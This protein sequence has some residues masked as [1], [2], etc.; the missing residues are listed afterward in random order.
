M[1]PDV[2]IV[3]GGVIGLSLADCLL[4]EGLSVTILDKGALGQEASW[5]GAGMLTCRP[6]L[7][8]ASKQIAEEMCTG[9]EQPHP[10]TEECGQAEGRRPKAEGRNG[11]PP[12]PPLNEGG[13]NGGRPQAATPVS[14]EPDI[15][16][17]KLLSVRRFPVWAERLKAETG[18]DI[19]YRVCGALEV[20]APGEDAAE[21]RKRLA[22][23]AAGCTARGV[24]AEWRSGEELRQRERNLHREITGGL[25]FPDEAQV[26]N[27][28]FL[29]ALI[30]SVK[31]KGARILEGHAVADVL[32]EGKKNG[33][34]PGPPLN[35][36]GENGDA[37]NRVTGV[38]LQNGEKIAAGIV[39]L[40]AG[41]WV[42][43]FPSVVRAAPASGKIEPV[44]GQ[45]IA[46]QADPKLATRLL[47]C[48]NHYIVPR[49]D[50]VILLGATHEKAGFDKMTTAQGR[51][52]LEN[53]SKK[54]LPNLSTCA[55]LKTW[56]GLRPGMKGRHPLIGPVG[57]MTGLFVAA[58]HYRNGLVLSL[59]TA[60]VLSAIIVKKTSPLSIEPWLPF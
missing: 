51:E 27:P 17:L 26:R 46:Y 48:G 15:S 10:V 41:A 8:P 5:A 35:E 60:E 30:A 52:E 24:R 31:A 11:T 29:R 3:G 38:V 49:G 44:R 4:R 47:T 59:A 2:L 45:I 50:G 1:K 23:L 20:L 13:E 56:A 14:G 25:E 58:G 42:A 22:D 32:V 43:Q 36:G 6:R 9:C 33:T 53:F 21:D 12:G 18:V 39:V 16:D 34:P 40:C 7:R 19:G 28:W 57:K 55:I 37:S 54:V